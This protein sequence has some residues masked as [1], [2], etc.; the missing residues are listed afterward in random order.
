M[1]QKLLRL[2]K[3]LTSKSV[4]RVALALTAVISVVVGCVEADGSL[5]VYGNSIHQ[6]NANFGNAL[7]KFDSTDIATTDE[8]KQAPENDD[9]ALA[10]VSNDT[11]SSVLFDGGDYTLEP[12]V[13][14]STYETVTE[15]V[16]FGYKTVYSD[17]LYKG[18]SK[19]TKGQNGEKSITYCVTSVNGMVMSREVSD[20]KV[21]KEAVPQV[22]TIGTK[23]HSAEAVK[24]SDEVKSIS[25]LTPDKPIELDK[26]G[27]PVNYTKVISGKASAYC[28]KCDNNKTAI[29][30]PAQPGLVAVNFNQI[31]KYTK[32]Y[33]V[34]DDG[35][36]Y[37][38]SIAADTGGFASNGSN[39]VADVRM[40]TGSK[41]NCGSH[42]GVKNIKIYIL[43]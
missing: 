18:E 37:G 23:L 15:T 4:L 8:E 32:M 1:L 42:W 29:G 30:L 26:N 9:Q 28:G 34:C 25:T 39:R 10:D 16:K 21:T 27:I 36:V 43:E 40:P 11:V 35:T 6:V 33:I 17:K 12:V 14:T 22:E 31:P 7:E 13:I 41:C 24:T 38:Y 5:V 19:T 20:E 2:C 3:S